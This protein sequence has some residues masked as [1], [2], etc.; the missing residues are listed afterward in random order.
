MFVGPTL[1][2]FPGQIYSFGYSLD[3]S[4]CHPLKL[5]VSS[6]LLPS[7]HLAEPLIHERPCHCPG[8]HTGRSVELGMSHLGAQLTMVMGRELV[9][10]SC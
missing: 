4:T 2:I 1:V 3:D 8:F 5:N 9:E 10:Q 6:V 7:P